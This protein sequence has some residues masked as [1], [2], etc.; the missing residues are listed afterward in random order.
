MNSPKEMRKNQNI[1]TLQEVIDNVKRYE[2]LG[3][4]EYSIWIDSHLS[5]ED[6]KDFL[7]KFITDVI[8]IFIMKKLDNH[9]QL[10]I[11]GEWRSGS[12][13]QIMHSQNPHNNQTWA[14][15]DCAS[16]KDIDLAVQ[17]AKDAL[18][19]QSWKSMKQF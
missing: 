10:Y 13:N 7:D 11:N 16:E 12:T 4:D 14:S 9:F 15:F 8:K 17:S 5:I 6:K 18:N 3:F 2:D 19:N 1:G